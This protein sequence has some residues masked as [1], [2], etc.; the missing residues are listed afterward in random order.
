MPPEVPTPPGGA[1]SN[2]REESTEYK[3]TIGECTAAFGTKTELGLHKKSAHPVEYND[4]INTQRKRARWSKEEIILLAKAEAAAAPD[5]VQFMNQH[6]AEKFPHRTLEAIKKRRQCAEYKSIVEGMLEREAQALVNEGDGQS[7]ASSGIWDHKSGI[8]DEIRHILSRMNNPNRKTR[9]LIDIAD[10]VMLGA[11]TNGR[12]TRW[13]RKSFRHARLPKGPCVQ[14]ATVLTGSSAQKRRK[15]YAILQTLYDK[16]IG[17]ATR[18]VLKDNNEVI[19]MPASDEVTQFW[20]NIFES[21]EGSAMGGTPSWNNN[22]TLNQLWAPVKETDVRQSEL[23]TNSAAGPDG[24][25]VD[26]WRKVP[27]LTRS[28]FYNLVLYTGHLEKELCG[29][30][31]VLIPKETGL[32]TPGAFRPLSITSVVVRQLHKMFASRLKGLH[33]FDERQRAFTDCD[34]TMENLTILSAI[35]THA[36]QNKK[37]VHVATLDIRKAFDSV[38][39]DVIHE[40]IR[41]IGC[42]KVFGE[43]MASLYMNATT[44]LQYA[45]RNTPVN[46]RRGVLQGDPL[47]PLLFNAVMDRVIRMIDNDVGYMLNGKTF[48]CVAYADDIILISSTKVGMQTLLDKLAS[49]LTAIGLDL[50]TDKSSA[51]SMVPS[52]KEKKMKTV[53][54]SLY[55][56]NGHQLKQIGVLDTWKY[57]GVYFE[58]SKVANR[59]ISLNDDL[60]KLTRA[61]L[62]PQQ[63]I[64]MLQRTV[65]PQHLHSLILGRT[66]MS[67]LKLL[68]GHVRRAI[69]KWLDLPQD[70]PLAYFYAGIKDGGLGIPCLAEMVPAIRKSRLEKFLNTGTSAATAMAESVHVS[71]Q[72]EWC[73]RALSHIG[74]NVTKES[75]AATWRDKL[76]EKFDTKY[77]SLSRHAKASY[78]W[79]RAKAGEITGKDYVHYHHLRVGCLPSRAR[80]LRG[81]EGSRN[82]RAGCMVS[83]TNRHTIQQCHRTH[84]GRMMRHDRIVDMLAE[85]LRSREGY[86]VVKEPRFTTS[87]GLRKPD[88]L[89]TKDRNTMVLDVQ[90]V[91]GTNLRQ[92]HANKIQ[93]YQDIP[94]LMEKVLRKCGSERVE[95]TA[96]TISYVGVIEKDT[97][98]VLNRLNVSEHRRFMMVTSVLRG[99]WLNWRRFNQMTTTSVPMSR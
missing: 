29:A 57:L 32:L 11:E 67:K 83:E 48:N 53:T 73:K 49:A 75:R 44:I 99:S 16:D 88:L 37:E 74:D 22:P 96:V 65:I 79:V 93:K 13:L 59:K 97:N 27:A 34:G 85:D 6:L 89:I 17:A 15:E 54:N 18:I 86:N 70:V 72:I 38:P 90:I 66:T 21:T 92:D 45:A 69:R 19:T 60:Q 20:K 2:Q 23:D 30:R 31:T 76:D 4:A 62:K 36:R 71:G 28:L 41:Q 14:T 24:V 64:E 82:C 40:T 95:C 35:V 87:A 55:R 50:N 81:R 61:P 77:L 43:Y 68:D 51:M 33:K 25:S 56:I 94:D 12:L 78:S 1:V 46:I 63:R 80:T 91:S 42:P 10:D 52:G 5:G 58:G 39:H 8:L 84:G 26:N 9:E 98:E 3:C 7:A 47:S